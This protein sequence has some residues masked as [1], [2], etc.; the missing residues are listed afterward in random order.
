M[1]M[2]QSIRRY[3]VKEVRPLLTSQMQ[4]TF[5]PQAVSAYAAARVFDGIR[6]VYP[7]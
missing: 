4:Q 1:E 5:L 7:E 3:T 2:A 6:R